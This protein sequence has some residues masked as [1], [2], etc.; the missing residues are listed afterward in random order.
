MLY[1]VPFPYIAILDSWDSLDI[2]MDGRLDM[3]EF[4]EYFQ[5][6]S[7]SQ[8]VFESLDVNGDHFIMKEEIVMAMHM[9]EEETV[10]GTDSSENTPEGNAAETQSSSAS[11]SVPPPRGMGPGT[12]ASAPP[13]DTSGSPSATDLLKGE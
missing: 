13:P 2:N 8:T 1:Q 9:L 4:S 6:S 5:Q 3:Y 7:A 10:E 11:V 12:E